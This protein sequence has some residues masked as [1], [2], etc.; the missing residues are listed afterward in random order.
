MLIRAV[1]VVTVVTAVAGG[2]AYA[3]I[4]D[5]NLVVHGCYKTK[6]GNLRVIDTGLGA[7]CKKGE[8][9]LPLAAAVPNAAW[10]TAAVGNTTQLFDTGVVAVSLQCISNNS[11]IHVD[12]TDGGNLDMEAVQNV[13]ATLA[14]TAT[15]TNTG[16]TF[17]ATGQFVTL[18]ISFHGGASPGTTVQTL[19]LWSQQASAGHGN[20]C[21][22]QGQWF[23][24]YA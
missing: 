17:T 24:S 4:P 5:S 9:A 22:S 7:V 11:V 21:F 19:H 16:V 1:A 6:A 8:T 13:G 18:L 2:I 3:S 23:P 15:T 10:V 14:T 20:N 12:A